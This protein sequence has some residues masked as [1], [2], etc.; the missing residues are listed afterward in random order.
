MQKEELVSFLQSFR[1]LAQKWREQRTPDFN[2]FSLCGVGT[3]E[4]RH[5]AIL[6]AL[7][8]PKG[9]HGLGVTP[10]KL[11]LEQ[12][13]I[14]GIAP[15]WLNNAT[16][17]T[18]KWIN[19]RWRRFDIFI[20]DYRNFSI[21]IENKTESCD[22][23]RQLADYRQWL[24]NQQGANKIAE[25]IY[26]TY[27]G[28]YA[29][30]SSINPNRYIRL[31]YEKHVIAW[32]E[33]CGESIDKISP[34]YFF[35]SQYQ[36][37]VQKSL[38]QENKK[39]EYEEWKDQLLQKTNFDIACEIAEHFE[40]IRRSAFT[41]LFNKWGQ[42]KAQNEPCEYL[43]I[44]SGNS[45]ASLCFDYG[46]AD[47]RIGFMFAASGFQN[48]Y[49]GLSWKDGQKHPISYQKID[50][51]GTDEWWPYWKWADHSFRYPGQNNDLLFDENKQNQLYE[52]LDSKLDE[53]KKLL[54]RV[55]R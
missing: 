24:D 7:L 32:L 27:N 43:P 29:T 9:T 45:Y 30:D 10:L 4:T 33:K 13:G 3:E 8:D 2:V 19:G 12:C 23:E 5:S 1:N 6:A 11:F 22:H 42:I 39:M 49:Y 20:S 17:E 26:L 47:L 34:V 21:V 50:G 36:K 55:R 16:V 53:L 31:S 35:I 44:A 14:T 25:L 37:F 52:F 40:P 54:Q 38:L 41:D 51:W 18:E 46:H 15:D 48:L 28:E